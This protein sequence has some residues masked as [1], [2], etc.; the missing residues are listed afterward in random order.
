MDNVITTSQTLDHVRY[1]I[2]TVFPTALMDAEWSANMVSYAFGWAV[3]CEDLEL[4]SRDHPVLRKAMC[5]AARQALGPGN[6]VL[7]KFV[8]TVSRGDSVSSSS[9]LLFDRATWILDL[10]ALTEPAADQVVMEFLQ[11]S[12]RMLQAALTLN[13]TPLF[14][15]Y[16]AM[17]SLESIPG[18]IDVSTYSQ[19]LLDEDVG[20]SNTVRA[21]LYA[22]FLLAESDVVP[23]RLSL[24]LCSLVRNFEDGPEILLRLL[25]TRLVTFVL[26]WLSKRATDRDWG[27]MFRYPDTVREMCLSCRAFG[28]LVLGRVRQQ[29]CEKKWAFLYHPSR[30]SWFSSA[31]C[32]TIA[33]AKCP[34]PPPTQDVSIFDDV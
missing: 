2:G 4:K 11:H 14:P 3:H 25:K 27:R 6:D 10:P 29:P 33:S 26:R 12:A 13:R 20:R 21:E 17:R 28:M 8:R 5:E 16:L 24:R 31:V 30:S 22:S 19:E 15:A 34:P 9:Q 7:C 23:P 32:R 18:V 1:F